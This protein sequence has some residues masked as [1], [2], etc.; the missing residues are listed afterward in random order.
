[1][2]SNI[3]RDE[4]YKLRFRD[5]IQGEYGIDVNSISV[6]RRGFYGETWKVSSLN[7]H[8]FLK[9]VCCREHMHIYEQSLPIVQYLCDHGI[10][11]IGQIVKTRHGKLSTY[12]DGAVVG[13]FD[14]IEGENIETDETKI[15]EYEMLAKVYAIPYQGVDFLYEDFSSR[16][17]DEFWMHLRILDNKQILSLIDKNREKLE[18]RTER[19]NL[20][21]TLCRVDKTGFVITHGD[22]G[23][24]FFVSKN[25]NF[26]LDWDGVM[27]APPERDA[28]VMCSREWARDAFHKALSRNSIAYKLRTERLAYYCYRFFFFYLNSFI[29][30]DSEADVVTAFLDGWIEDSF[31]WADAI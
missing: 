11:F 16:C 4:E 22:A 14:W 7:T 5:F 2:Y 12:F 19:L 13:V 28:W 8:Y 24:N 3:V 23:G 15:P 30:A 31:R 21:S 17:S 25:R 20:F 9:V 18:Y 26:I 27:L 1:M 10:D 6:A 29:A